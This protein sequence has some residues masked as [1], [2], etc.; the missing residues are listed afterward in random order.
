MNR[1]AYAGILA[2]VFLVISFL[3]GCGTSN[4]TTHW[5]TIVITPTGGTTQSAQIN[6]PFAT[7]LQAAVTANGSPIS[8]ASVT[9]TAP[10]S[11]ASGVFTISGT[12]TETDTTN[13]NGVVTSSTF[14][15]N[16]T[17]G[18]Y[19]V[20]ASYAGATAPASYS[21][22]N[23]AVP[24][25]AFYLS[26]LERT[27][28]SGAGPFFYAVAGSVAID[29]NGNVA[30]GEL[31]YND[32]WKSNYTSNEPTAD[33]ISGGTLTLDD[34]GQGQLALTDAT[35][36]NV[37]LNGV[38]TLGVQFVN[39][40]HALITQFDS[41]AT[42]SGSLDLQNLASAP[43][44]NYAFTVSGVDSDYA[45]TASGGVFS[46]GNAGALSGVVDTND[47]GDVSTDQT[48]AGTVKTSDLYGR[49]QIT[50]VGQ[51]L[52]YYI[53]GPEVMRLIDVDA[54][55]S[56]V[57]SAFGQGSTNGSPN[58]FSNS[59]LGK[60][61][62]AIE[63]NEAPGVNPYGAV[64]SFTTVPGSG[65]FS[66]I[67]DDDEIYSYGLAPDSTISGTYSIA[68][69]G[70]GSLL[71]PPAAGV[72]QLGYITTLG[73][74]MTDPNLNL[75]DPNNTSS[76]LGGALIADLDSYPATSYATLLGTGVLIPQTDTTFGNSFG[77]ANTYDFG[78]Q[79]SYDIPSIDFREF[80]FVGNAAAST[81]TLTGTGLLTDP[82]F[83]WDANAE[84]LGVTF[85]GTL[86]PD[87]N[88]STTGRSTMS[89][90][91]TPPTSPLKIT[92]GAS[93][94]TFDTVVYQTSGNYLFW[95]DENPTFLFLG[96]IE[97]QG[98][99]AGVPGLPAARKAAA[100]FAKPKQK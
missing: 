84:N 13:A 27:A 20:T 81:G 19:S 78:G 99:L 34:T 61:V 9:F 88:E 49:G 95:L 8:G 23:T 80:D 100:K 21:L 50:G 63:S 35:D 26:G 98:A 46:I 10:A 17:A 57:G 5:P 40:K 77:N 33:T 64:G 94:A 24:T 58:T 75:L 42:S 83:F 7:K 72:Y 87:A 73:I 48:F 15:A 56:Y 12:A 45:P 90:Y 93:W 54:D 59:S 92:V 6:Q 53:V 89:Q 97:Q 4:L 22:T 37:G 16:A 39:S 11:G 3:T 96:P 79:T 66:G 91:N 31:D 70:Y 74:Y 25:F 52:I 14:T 44:G 38:I 30:G 67:A 32:G 18:A 76:G 41:G 36:T 29:V 85:A 43:G 62:F 55:D 86:V 71:M 28:P 65:T 1:N 47:A 51:T 60:S 68:S 2:V 69:N 82:G